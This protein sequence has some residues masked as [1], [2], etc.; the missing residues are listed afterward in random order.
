MLPVSALVFAPSTEF[1]DNLCVQPHTCPETPD[2]LVKN[3]MDFS[4]LSPFPVGIDR[5]KLPNPRTY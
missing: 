5:G 2:H 4:A 1:T 3:M